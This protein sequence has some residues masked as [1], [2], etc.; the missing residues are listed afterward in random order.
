VAAKAEGYSGRLGVS[1]IG[2]LGPGTLHRV[3]AAAQKTILASG[4]LA[5]GPSPKHGKSD[6][7]AVRAKRVREA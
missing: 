7:L 3:T 4:M 6:G 1:P 5:V 2:T